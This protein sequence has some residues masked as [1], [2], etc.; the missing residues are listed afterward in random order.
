MICLGVCA[1][2]EFDGECVAVPLVELG[3][4]T[5][6][7]VETR[8]LLLVGD[9]L[10]ELL[11]CRV[12]DLVEARILEDQ[13]VLDLIHKTGFDDSVDLMVQ[14]EV[15]QLMRQKQSYSL[16]LHLC[17]LKDRYREENPLV[18]IKEHQ[19]GVVVHQ[20]YLDRQ[21]LFIIAAVCERLLQVVRLNQLFQGLLNQE[22]LLGVLLV[23]IV[24]DL[25]CHLLGDQ[26]AEDGTLEGSVHQLVLPI[27]RKVV[28][29]DEEPVVEA[30]G[31][32]WHYD[33]VPSQELRCRLI[34]F[35]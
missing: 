16:F 28:A 12:V 19:H 9:F 29:A 17:Q 13:D 20:G 14:D 2:E 3:D 7:G 27:L 26:G 11:L 10:F 8:I 35:V 33:Q 22:Y 31:C 30:Q 23:H 1:H 18:Q 15:C 24:L 5:L 6:L 25:G 21:L 32:H 34:V 4:Y